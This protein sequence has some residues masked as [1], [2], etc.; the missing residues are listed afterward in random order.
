MHDGAQY[1][2]ANQLSDGDC[3]KNDAQL[4][5]RTNN[6]DDGG[7]N[8]QVNLKKLGSHLTIDVPNDKDKDNH[9]LMQESAAIN[10]TLLV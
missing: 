4:D 8:V 5:K 1:N 3:C 7:Q 10:S 2:Y 6:V 9:L